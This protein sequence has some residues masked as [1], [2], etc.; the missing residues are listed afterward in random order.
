[1]NT[2][3]YAFFI[4]LAGSWHCA[5]MCGPIMQQIEQ[6]SHQKGRLALYTMG[7]L[8]M[9]GILG[10]F[11]AKIGSI[12]LFPSWWHIYYLF[13]G[14][15]LILLLSKKI[16]DNLLKF[17][18]QHIGKFLIRIGKSLGA[19]GYFFLGM[20]NGLLPCGLVLGGLSIALLQSNAWL[21]ALSMIS[22]GIA[23]LPALKLTLW[24][25]NQLKRF[26]RLFQY[27]G[28]VI[29][30][31]LLFRGAYGIGMTQSNYLQHAALSPII[32]H[33]FS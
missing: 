18:H 19:S 3:Y 20:S 21:G 17:L 16:G 23:T 24:G 7:R 1:M 15:V 13:T 27:L 5:I 11:V 33:P 30:I 4:G 8:F 10:F 12:W 22:F 31:L 9:Y 28:W 25:I 14:I 32:C 29:A 2:W 26:N 6:R